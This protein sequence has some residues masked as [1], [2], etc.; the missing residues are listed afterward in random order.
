MKVRALPWLV[1]SW[2]VSTACGDD[3]S[4]PPPPTV[5]SGTTGG[6]GPGLPDPGPS[7][8]DETRPDDDAPDP[9]DT[10]GS[11][12]GSGFKFD[13]GPDEDAPRPVFPITCAEAEASHSNLGCEFWAVDLPNDWRGTSFSPPAADQQFAV[14]VANSSALANA[15]VSIYLGAEDTPLERLYV[16]PDGIWEFRLDSQSIRGDANS[17]DGVAYR[18]VSDTPITAYQFNPL[19]NAVQVYSNDASLLYPSH[20][21]TRDYTAVTGSAIWLSMGRD[22]PAPVLA[23]AFVSVV[24][25]EDDTTVDV[26]PH[27]P[28]YE[29]PTEAVPLDRGAVF[30]VLSDGD[31]G[32]GNLSG[33]RVEASKPVAVFAGNVATVEP[34][35]NGTC[36]ADHVEHQ[37]APLP[38][39]GTEYVA[40]PPPSASGPGD[41]PAVYRITGS[42]DG[43]SLQ[44][45]PRRPAGAPSELDRYE[46]IQFETDRPFVVTSR[47]ANK[48]FAVTQFLE[49]NGALNDDNLGDPAMLVL[50]ATEQFQDKYVFA[51]PDGYGHNF[52][53]VVRRGRGRIRIDGV[54]LDEAS[55]SNAG[56]LRGIM[57]FYAQVPL[58]AGPHV[59]QGDGRFAVSVF[60]YD[61][62]VSYGF[63]A[64][65]GLDV[66]APTPPAG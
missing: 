24:A 11:S 16:A 45:C 2:L 31:Q 35:D 59:I 55:F 13:V 44:Y 46:T 7:R 26:F 18:I 10:G 20:A 23:G 66:I 48:P 57:H 54:T 38:S 41:D 58:E 64:G 63:P 34:I 27:A 62:A 33:T 50:P 1:G 19:D 22:D 12:T 28:L 56:V 15:D 53:T 9:A 36:C 29:G 30:T 40:A 3:S 51:I 4:L 49:S 37:M 21:L 43:T 52:A 60:G 5:G 65:M 14:I 8:C 6:T 39:W 32:E 47:D 17:T 42:F 25:L 61:R